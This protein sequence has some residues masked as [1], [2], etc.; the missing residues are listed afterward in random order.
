MGNRYWTA[1][2]G[3]F[4][5]VGIALFFLTMF[6]YI[7]ASK[8]DLKKPYVIFFNTPLSGLSVGSVVEYRGIKVG[9]VVDL[10]LHYDPKTKQFSTPVIV[11]F[12]TR[13]G[14]FK[15]FP[16]PKEL[17]SRGAKARVVSDS[18]LSASSHV[19][20]FL[21]KQKA[22]FSPNDTKYTQIPVSMEPNGSEMTDLNDLMKSAKVTLSKSNKTLS[23]LDKTLSNLDKALHN[24]DVTLNSTN[25]FIKG[26]TV[27]RL[28]SALVEVKDAANSARVLFDYLARHP[29]SIIIGKGKG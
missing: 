27:I 16:D 15:H 25:K 24:F 4:F 20:L 5:F 23:N 7:P 2:L 22:Y 11:N 21:S 10:Y 8:Y 19:N 17:I 18:L 14:R 26:P 28:D 13:Y 1:A 6:W 9:K 3:I 29:E 12:L